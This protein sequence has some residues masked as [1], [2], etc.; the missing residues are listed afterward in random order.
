M[1]LSTSAR[2]L[3][4]QKSGWRSQI[5]VVGDGEKV[6][7]CYYLRCTTSL[8]GGPGGSGDEFNDQSEEEEEILL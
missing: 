2:R 5:F 8:A 6:N 7:N 1:C 3:V 4:L